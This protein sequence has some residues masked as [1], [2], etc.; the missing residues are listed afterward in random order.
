MERK[1]KKLLLSLLVALGSVTALNAMSNQYSEL[2]DQ[3][4]TTVQQPYTGSKAQQWKEY[5]KKLAAYRREVAARNQWK[6]KVQTEPWQNGRVN[7]Y[8]QNSYVNSGMVRH[9]EAVRMTPRVNKDTAQHICKIMNNPKNFKSLKGE[10]HAHDCRC[11]DGRLT[12]RTSYEVYS[13][14]DTSKKRSYVAVDFKDPK[15]HPIIQVT[16]DGGLELMPLKRFEM[17]KAYQEKYIDPAD[18]KE[19]K[20]YKKR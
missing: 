9:N 20:I 4:E 6:P 12:C 10:N 16:K 13:S 11:N 1:M 2:Y 3:N 15:N 17:E 7:P 19:E 14:T 18:N 8:R 5:Y